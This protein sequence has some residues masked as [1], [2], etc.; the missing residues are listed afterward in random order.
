[1]YR[2]NMRVVPVG[3]RKRHGQVNARERG[4]RLGRL[5]SP[6][7]EVQLSKLSKPLCPLCGTASVTLA[8][9]VF[10]TLYVAGQGVLAFLIFSPLFLPARPDSRG[11]CRFGIHPLTVGG[12]GSGETFS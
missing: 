5:G 9:E 3:M 4:S 11:S 2:E 12:G 1:V 7:W 8:L 10:L 6:C